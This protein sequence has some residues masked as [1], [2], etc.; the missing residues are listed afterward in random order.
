MATLPANVDLTIYRRTT[1][2]R[3]FRWRPGGAGTTPQNFTGWSGVVRIG[4]LHQPA[5]L[6][7][8]VTL[9][10]AGLVTL[11]VSAA[12]TALMAPGILAYEVD[13]TGPDLSVTRFLRGRVRVYSDVEPEEVP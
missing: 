2:R 13:L 6:E 12:N 5:L 7:D 4:P 8:P 1:F 9:D 11:Q 10:A 3:V